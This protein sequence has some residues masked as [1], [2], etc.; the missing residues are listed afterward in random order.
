MTAEDR[1][2]LQILTTRSGS[3]STRQTSIGTLH[4]VYHGRTS[5]MLL[6]LQPEGLWMKQMRQEQ[7]WSA[8]SSG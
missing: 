8:T 3:L 5:T 6:S 2:L 4:A 7:V 1:S